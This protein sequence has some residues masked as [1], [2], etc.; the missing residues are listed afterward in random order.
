MVSIVPNKINNNQKICLFCLFQYHDMVH[1]NSIS[2]LLCKQMTK[3]LQLNVSAEKIDFDDWAK[4][5]QIYSMNEPTY[6]FWRGVGGKFECA[7][8]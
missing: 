2:S 1:S 7:R 6:V 4:Y 3:C 5:L 8:G